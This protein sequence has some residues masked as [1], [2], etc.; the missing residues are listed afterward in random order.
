MFDPQQM[1]QAMRGMQRAYFVTLFKPGMVQAAHA[2]ADAARQTGLET[3]VQLSQ[4][5]SHPTHPSIQ[6]RETWQVDQLLAGIAGTDHII[7]NPGMFADNFLRVIDYASL[8]CFYPVLTADS[9]SAPVANEDIARVVVALL[10]QPDGQ[11]GRRF[12]PT[13][14]Q[15]LTGREMAR[16]IAQ[17]V[18]HRVLPVDLP[19][20]MFRKAARQ[21][22]ADIHEIYNY[23]LYMQE[24]RRGTFSLGG[25]VTDVVERLTGAPAE[26]FEVTA[27]RYAAMPFASQTFANRIKAFAKFNVLPLVPAHGLKAYERRMGFVSPDNAALSIDDSAWKLAHKAQMD[28]QGMDRASRRAPPGPTD[29]RPQ[30]SIGLVRQP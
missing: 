20:W 22:G 6:T 25:G 16:V 4:W 23:G 13:G 26:S 8:L 19:M 29:V 1:V 30:A 5:L 3:V 9:A 11:A 27:A 18:G 28:E 7:V 14:P 24:H 2:F 12:R 15:L 21:S 17:V 10:K